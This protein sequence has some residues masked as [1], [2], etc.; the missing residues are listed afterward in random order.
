MK[1]YFRNELR[2][3]KLLFIYDLGAPGA[4]TSAMKEVPWIFGDRLAYSVKIYDEYISDARYHNRVWYALATNNRPRILTNKEYSNLIT[5]LDKIDVPILSEGDQFFEK[6]IGGLQKVYN[7]NEERIA[8][9][10]KDVFGFKMPKEATVILSESGSRRLSFGGGLAF[11]KKRNSVIFGLGV[12]RN[13]KSWNKTTMAVFI[14][15]LLHKLIAMNGTLKKKVD[16][17]ENPQYFEE[18]VLDYFVPNGIL[19]E[20]LGLMEKKDISSHKKKNDAQREVAKGISDRLLIPI[21]E[22]SKSYGKVT[23]WNFLAKRGFAK[24]IN[25][26]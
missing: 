19:G 12:G 7:T 4:L 17:D 11:D 26:K 5:L 20:K 25:N 1:I 15:E 18:A 14:H 2:L 13:T 10:I 8:K 9:H 6:L 16:G 3:R 23:I 21:K 24:Y 22:Y